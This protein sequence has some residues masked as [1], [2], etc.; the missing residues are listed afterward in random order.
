MRKSI[1]TSDKQA[2]KLSATDLVKHMMHQP[3]KHNRNIRTDYYQ[4]N[5]I[6]KSTHARWA[7]NAVGNAVKHMRKQTY[8]STHC[9]TYDTVTGE[10][11]SV[12]RYYRR[13]RTI[14]VLF[15]HPAHESEWQDVDG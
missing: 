4:G 12:I 11:H 14:E 7:N 1:S 8:D 3:V 2:P 6:V 9:E 15:T 13:K 5:R 10:L